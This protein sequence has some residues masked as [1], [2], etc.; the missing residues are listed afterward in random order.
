[1]QADDESV[2]AMR[3]NATV[4]LARIKSTELQTGLRICRFQ[5]DAEQN[6]EGQEFG[7]SGI[8]RHFTDPNAS[9][10]PLLRE[11]SRFAVGAPLQDDATVVTIEVPTASVQRNEPDSRRKSA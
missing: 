8:K 3:Q 5:Y 9:T 7:Y 6:L 1:M 2:K 11:V 10:E 4:R